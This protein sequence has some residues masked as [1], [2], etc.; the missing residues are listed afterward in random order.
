M[1]CA[2]SRRSSS[3]NPASRSTKPLALWRHRCRSPANIIPNCWIWSDAHIEAHDEK[4]HEQLDAFIKT[5][6][7]GIDRVRE[8][9]ESGT[10]SVKNALMQG[11]Q[12]PGDGVQ[13]LQ[14]HPTKTADRLVAQN[15]TRTNSWT[16]FNQ[17]H[18]HT[19]DMTNNPS[20]HAKRVIDDP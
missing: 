8:G 15:E 6:N 20:E 14:S 9:L 16:T 1:L 12:K 5:T 13:D 19:K 3:T 10:T 17:M 11:A 4:A 7:Q 2:I 18:E